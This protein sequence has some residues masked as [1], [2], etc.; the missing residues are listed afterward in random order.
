MKTHNWLVLSIL[1]G[2]PGAI[3]AHGCVFDSTEECLRA[4]TCSPADC[5]EAADIDDAEVR[6]YFLVELG[7]KPGT[8]SGGGGTGAGGGQSGGGGGTGGAEPCGGTCK[9]PTPLCDTKT[10][11]C[12]A[13]L[14]HGDCTDADAARCDA[15][16]CVP[17]QDSAECAGVAEGAVCHSSSCVECALDDESACTGGKTCD[18]LAFKCVDVAAGSVLNCKSC[19]ND[20]QCETGYRCIA[21]DFNKKAHGYYCLKESPGCNNPFKPLVNKTSLNGA[22]ATDY[23]GIDQDLATCEAV[24]ALFDDWRCP[25]GMDELCGPFG[26]EEV[27][28]PGALCRTVGGSNNQCTYACTQAN[29]CLA[30]SPGNT[31]GGAPAP[32]WCGG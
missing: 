3:V 23:C 18:L 6:E 9:A 26:D 12:V 29:Q 1:L 21:M 10:N 22:K 5:D 13:C 19:S 17:C 2:A 15:G 14:G 31:C 32:K 20:T 4:H 24:L 25:S 16:S 7:C 27:A 11:M 28:T 8:S 30:G